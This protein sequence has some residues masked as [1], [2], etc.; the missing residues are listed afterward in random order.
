MS[1]SVVALQPPAAIYREEQRFHWWVYGILLLMAWGLFEG[2][3]LV[4]PGLFGQRAQQLFFVVA[5]GLSLPVV[6]ALGFLRMTTVVTPSD[7][8]VWFGFLASYRRN[9]SIVTIQ[10]V[11]IVQFRPLAEHGG[12]GVRYSRDGDRVYTARGTRGVR[13]H[14]IDGTRI[15]IG[16]QRAEELAQALEGAMRSCR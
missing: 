12:W 1:L 16:S 3:G 14:L 5:A 8:R 11:E 10:A 2:R 15:I 9:L 6:F 7:V 4:R 13:V